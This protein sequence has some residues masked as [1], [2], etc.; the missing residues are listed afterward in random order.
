M[1]ILE[2]HFCGRNQ[3]LL[4]LDSEPDLEKFRGQNYYIIPQTE[5]HAHQISLQDALL[6]GLFCGA[7]IGM[8]AGQ[9]IHLFR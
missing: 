7:F 2:G 9:Y 4:N 3:L 1:K 5:F 6:V 8:L